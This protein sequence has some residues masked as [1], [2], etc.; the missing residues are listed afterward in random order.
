MAKVASEPYCAIEHSTL[1]E[2]EVLSWLWIPIK[3]VNMPRAKLDQVFQ[4]EARATTIKTFQRLRDIL[5]DDRYIS[6]QIVFVGHAFGGAVAAIVGLYFAYWIQSIKLN[7]K[8]L[9]FGVI[10]FGAPRIGDEKFN[11]ISNK[12]VPH[13]RYTFENDHVPHFPLRVKGYKHSGFEI[14]IKAPDCDCLPK[15]SSVE[16]YDCNS[17]IESPSWTTITNFNPEENPNC[18]AGRSIADIPNDH[19]HNGP[20]FGQIMGDCPREKLERLFLL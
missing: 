19:F 13:A 10:S 14:W 6:S 4:H 7:L 16:Y 8:V 1:R 3:G 2:N 18:N 11:E 12:M 15:D 9:T 5:S 20:Y 17:R